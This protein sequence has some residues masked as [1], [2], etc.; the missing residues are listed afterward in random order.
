MSRR[1]VTIWFRH[2]KTDWHTRRDPSLKDKT[3]VISEMIHGRMVVTAVNPAAQA[4]GIFPGTVVA[5]AR[6]IFKDLKVIEGKPGVEQ[7]LLKN[8]SLWCIRFTPVV[9]IDLPEGLILDA[10]GCAHLWGSE[11]AYINDITQKLKNFGYHVNAAISDTI[12][13]SWAMSRFCKGN[14]IIRKGEHMN[15]L[16]PMP[17]ESLRFDSGTIERLHKLGLRHVKDFIGMPRQSLRRR[18]GEYFLKR[19]DQ[20]LGYEEEYIQPEEPLQPYEERLPSLEPIITLAGIE[21]ALRRLLDALCAR[22]MQDG[23]GIRHAILKMFTADGKCQQVSVSTSQP[24]ANTLHLFKLFEIKFSSINPEKGIEVFVLEATK[25][26]I[27]TAV[28]EKLFSSSSVI[29]NKDLAEFIDRLTAKFGDGHIKRFLPDEHYWPERSF[30]S[31]ASLDE[32]KT[33]EWNASKPRPLI[34]LENPEPIEVTAPIPDYPP[35]NF[36]HKGVLHKIDRADG[37]ERIEQEWWIEEGNHRDYYYVEDEDGKRYWLY[38]SGH[39]DENKTYGWYL[40]GYFA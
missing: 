14:T 13:C 36:R 9:S 38:R 23:K 6:A 15:E 8:L 10:T 4:K 1:F 7:K 26:E 5:D 37:P 33:S 32:P 40:H 29:S 24:S 39:Y 30:K 20:A 21:I 12:G 16:L 28:Q 19:L 25:V 35:M 3:I 27:I 11:T 22:L 34:L 31:T 17:S 18:F 2:L